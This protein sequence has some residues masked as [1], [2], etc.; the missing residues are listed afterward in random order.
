[1]SLDRHRGT[2]VEHD[3]SAGHLQMDQQTTRRVKRENQHF[4]T[5]SH[6]AH[7]AAHH[8]RFQLVARPSEQFGIQLRYR[9]DAAADQHGT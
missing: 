5:P 9:L 7:G 3:E 6:A 1:M 4:A 2:R 8:T